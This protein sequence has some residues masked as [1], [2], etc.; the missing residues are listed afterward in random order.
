MATLTMPAIAVAAAQTTDSM[1]HAKPI[2][3]PASWFP[4]DAYPIEARN[5]GQ[6]G[7]TV[8]RLQIDAQGRVMQCDIVQSS[9]SVQLDNTTCD[10]VLTN[11]HFAPAHDA[12]GKAVP[13]IWQSAMRWQLVAGSPT[14][15]S[16]SD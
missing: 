9:G 7:R 4:A 6:E 13:G 1:P 15:D 3:N 12:T 8:F 5:A 16:D 10:L 11:G 14:V 2:G